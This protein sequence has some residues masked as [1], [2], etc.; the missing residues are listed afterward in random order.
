VCPLDLI[1]KTSR[2]NREFLKYIFDCYESDIMCDTVFDRLQFMIATHESYDRETK[3]CS[4]HFFKLETSKLHEMSF[5]IIC[6]IISHPF[7]K[8]RDEDLLY[9][10]IK[11]LVIDE[12]RYLNLFEHVR[13]GYLSCESMCSFIE[14]IWKSFEFLTW[15]I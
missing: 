11:S 1:P 15:S 9:E 8:L 14:V 7:L 2:W 13:F 3:F 5:E 6:A 10:F 4:S 12:S